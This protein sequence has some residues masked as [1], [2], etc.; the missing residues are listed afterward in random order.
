MKNK[1]YQHG[2]TLIEIMISLLIGAFL[3]GGILQIFI[4]TRQTY[5]LQENLS[6]MQENGR[7]ALEFLARDIRMAGYWGCLKAVNGDI[8]G[9]DND[10]SSGTID[11]GTDSLTIKGAFVLS[12][13]G[14]CGDN[15]D[16][17][18]TYYTD[19]SASIVYKINESVLQKSTNNI[20][21]DLI[22]DI[23]DMQILYGEN[24]N[25]NADT[26]PSDYVA[27]Y[28]VSADKVVNWEQVF[29]I[30]ISLLVRSSEDNLTSVPR[31][32]DYNGVNTTPTD[33]RLR[34]IFTS[35]IA[36]RNRLS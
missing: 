14:I 15:V 25:I 7:F 5:R 11:D 1:S 29:S 6:R 21:V 4:S 12:P 23:E 31:A 3:I 13:T 33:Y 24:T 2:M 32:Y 8:S 16:I 27:N 28:Y 18:Q 19:P 34:R 17:T 9:T 26:T 36:V 30:K 22:D 10:A 35:T 20:T